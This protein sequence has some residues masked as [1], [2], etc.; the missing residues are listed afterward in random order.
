MNPIPQVQPVAQ[1]NESGSEPRWPALV[2]LLAVG[3]LNL[4]LSAQ[5]SVG[6]RWV[7][8]LVV[9]LLSIPTVLT[10]RAKLNKANQILGFIIAGI[11]TIALIGSVCLLVWVLIHGG[12]KPIPLLQSAALLWI[13][14]VLIFALWYW[15]LDAG[16]PHERDAIPGHTRG[17]ILF[18]QM[19][20]PN[21]SPNKDKDWEPQFVDYLFLAFNN[22]TALSPTDAPVL[23]RW[24]KVLTMMQA[25][26][27]LII[28]VLLAARAV[29]ILS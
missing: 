10:H 13:S 8:P 7:L 29:N 2:A 6:P 4:A 1:D 27:S 28:V 24:A 17:A 11:E 5:I 19:T 25:S 22:S 14:N 20:I 23:S 9:A 18:P 21:D 16:G 12:E 26:I 15:R 3:G